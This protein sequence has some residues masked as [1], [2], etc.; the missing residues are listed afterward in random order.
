[1]KEKTLTERMNLELSTISASLAIAQK[2]RGTPELKKALAVADKAANKSL[3]L[4]S[5]IKEQL[6]RI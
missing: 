3:E 5:E 2:M 1:M 6:R 4:L